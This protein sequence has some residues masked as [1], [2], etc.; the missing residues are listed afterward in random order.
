MNYKI[1]LPVALL[2]GIVL[3]AGAV[4]AS[5]QKQAPDHPFD[6]P[7]GE[8]RAQ[9]VA[10]TGNVVRV[11]GNDR[12]A[13]AAAISETVW[14]YE[15]TMVVF[16]ATGANYPDALGIGPS[17]EG[18]GPLLLTQRDSLPAP[19]RRELDRLRPCMIVAVGGTG[20]ISDAVLAD[21][22]QYTSDC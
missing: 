11:S 21:A 7:A 8:F 13:T 22:D 4:G 6:K 9:E 2:L 3:G 16:L 18:L 17:T 15:N 19:T 12:Y 1:V 10:A 5:A 20:V 14:D